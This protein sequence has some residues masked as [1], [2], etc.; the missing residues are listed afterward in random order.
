M[1]GV[2]EDSKGVCDIIRQCAKSGVGHI[3]IGEM[4]ISFTANVVKEEKFTTNVVGDFPKIT[5][6]EPEKESE[7]ERTQKIENLD[8]LDH[9]ILEDPEE[10]ERQ[11]ADEELNFGHGGN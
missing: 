4:E 8:R 7:N 11:L 3:K 9:L 2:I 1:L 5:P 10:F 6:I